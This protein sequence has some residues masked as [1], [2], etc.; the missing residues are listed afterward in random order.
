[1]TKEEYIE[2]AKDPIKFITDFRVGTNAYNKFKVE[3]LQ[4]F[5]FEKSIVEKIHKEDY[6]IFK[7]SRQ[8]HFSSIIASYVCWCAIFSKK[9]YISIISP[10]SG[11][12]SE[13]ERL[14]RQRSH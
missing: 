11:M 2:Y 12:A 5:E 14:T 1:M 7:K 10:N 8:M 9:K 4:M 6:S 13:L 3:K